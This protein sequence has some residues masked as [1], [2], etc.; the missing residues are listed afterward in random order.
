[1]AT[2]GETLASTGAMTGRAYESRSATD[3]RSSGRRHGPR[4]TTGLMS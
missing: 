1:M 3:E 2:T 4:R